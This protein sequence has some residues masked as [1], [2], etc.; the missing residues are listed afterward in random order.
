MKITLLLALT[1][2]SVS[3]FLQHPMHQSQ[4]LSTSSALFMAKKRK[5]KQTQKVEKTRPDTLADTIAFAENSKNKRLKDKP[6][7]VPKEPVDDDGRAARAVDAQERMDSRPDVS[8]MIVDAETGMEF[9]AQGKSVMDVVTRK[10]VV[11][12]NQGA[13]YR[14][15]QL[16][17]GVPPEVRAQ[18]RF[19]AAAT[20]PTMVEL[21]RT[22]CAVE[23]AIPAHP[24]VANKAIDFVVSNRDLLG[25]KMKRT[26]ARLRMRSMSLGN[27]E[28]AIE[29]QKLWKNFLTLENHI[30]APFRQIIM[31]AEGRCGPN[32]GNLDL[33]SFCNGQVYERCGN[34]LVLKGMVA[35]WEKKVVDADFTEKTEQTKENYMRVLARGDP[36][37]FLPDAPILFSVKECTQV[38]Y[39]AQQM[40]KTFVETPELFNDLP[41]ELRFL[42]Q[43]LNI[44]GGTALRKY[45]IEDFCPAEGITPEGLREGLRRLHAQLE[46]M[47]VDPYADICNIIERLYL[48]MAVGTDD[49]RDP[50]T[51]YLVNK[52]PDGPGAFQTYTFNHE[53]LSLV[54]FLDGQYEN[55]GATPMPK[56]SG[57][58]L[59]G[60]FN[61]GGASSKPVTPKTDNSKGTYKVPDARAAGRPHDLGWLDLL[62]EEKNESL[63]FGKVSPG[64]I[65]MENN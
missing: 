40:T 43:A 8:T 14:L 31:D 30:S 25:H 36:K 27:K 13:N 12:S 33:T 60:F 53:K 58:G 3:G 61:F 59:G 54:R 62:D 28:E 4:Q 45:V 5:A 7:P 51:E 29:Y 35:H 18:H 37:R 44:Q 16:L 32:F 63:R 34:Y 41:P 64:Q 48:A 6:E 52:D 15:A 23:G 9:V 26:L 20:V 49:E 21:L 65:I 42:E 56:S 10:A 47:Q 19:D 57:G 46:N 2:S 11:L 24:S 1:A 50:Y 39:M 38:C 55:A 22:A 17:P